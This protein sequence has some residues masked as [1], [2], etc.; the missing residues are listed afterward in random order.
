MYVIC[1]PWIILALD[2]SIPNNSKIVNAAHSRQ[3]YCNIINRK[4]IQ[5][6][7]VVSTSGFYMQQQQANIIKNS[8]H[9]GV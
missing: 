5:E 6:S 8:L 2:Y 1:T 9:M 3:R 7:I 4:S